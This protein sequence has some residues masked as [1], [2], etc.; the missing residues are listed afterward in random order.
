MH[1]VIETYSWNQD[2]YDKLLEVKQ[3]GEYVRVGHSSIGTVI[4]VEK[5]LAHDESPYIE[6]IFQ[7]NE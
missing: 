7:I 2:V 3:N 6:V 5:K 4:G 1:D